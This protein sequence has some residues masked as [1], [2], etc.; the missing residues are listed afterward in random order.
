MNPLK[1]NMINWIFYYDFLLS[2][3]VS[4][5]L[6]INDLHNHYMIN[7]IRFED[8]KVL[9]YWAINYC[10]IS[11]PIGMLIANILIGRLSVNT[12][13]RQYVK[14]PIVSVLSHKDSSMKI[15]LYGFALVSS[16]SLI[17]MFIKFGDVPLF[18]AIMGANFKALAQDRISISR[19][20]DGSQL[21]FN[22][23]AKDLP[24]F[25]TFIFYSYYRQTSSKQDKFWFYYML[26]F[27]FLSLTYD[28]SKAPIVFF[29]IGLFMNKIYI[30]G[31]TNVLKF[32]K[33]F[34]IAF[35]LLIFGYIVLSGS[36]YN[37]LFGDIN[38]GILGRIFLS[39][40]A[41]FY[42]MLEYFQNSVDQIG[43]S[44]FSQIL[45]TFFD[46]EYSD[47][48]ARIL[49]YNYDLVGIEDGTAGVIN[50]LFIGEAFANFGIWGILIAPLY[51][52]FIIQLLYKTMLRLPKTPIYLGYLTYFSY[53]SCINGGFNDYFYNPNFIM[54]TI[55]TFSIILIAKSLRLNR[56]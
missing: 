33:I 17:V 39:Q 32:L 18:K 38:N 20:N 5:V 3:F 50:S 1:P 55:F 53:K 25:I 40:S 46:T 52:G 9:G 27:T 15:V 35:L 43:F 10:L 28:L 14:K 22:F 24:V 48:A 37:E 51:V 19:I 16:I 2:T 45:A 23:F 34:L 6:V 44:S 8:T 30:D 12:L 56:P 4:S 7:K 13:Y 47:R 36:S 54:I 26:V 11:F 49:V 41:G 21:F 29:V 42:L 31:K